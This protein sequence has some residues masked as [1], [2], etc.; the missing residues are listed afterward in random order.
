M[1]FH[2]SGSFTSDIVEKLK[3]NSN[4]KKVKNDQ[5]G[6]L[7]PTILEAINDDSKNSS[8]VIIGEHLLHPLL[9]FSHGTGVIGNQYSIKDIKNNFWVRDNVVAPINAKIMPGIIK[10]MIEKPWMKVV[11]LG[12]AYTI[13]FPMWDNLR[14]HT[15]NKQLFN[16]HYCDQYNDELGKVIEA[17]N[18]KLE[19][20]GINPILWF[21]VV[22]SIGRTPDGIPL[23]VDGVH[24]NWV[25]ADISRGF[26]HWKKQFPGWDGKLNISSVHR[27]IVDVI[28]N[29]GCRGKIQGEINNL[30]CYQ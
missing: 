2:W 14:L 4:H 16:R 27:S 28:F 18:K 24:F 6:K 12:C 25:E 22:K 30:C 3:M 11:F 23:A 19:N 20:N 26:T 5:S 1:K 13:H 29:I 21:P 10:K 7:A 15:E 17:A 8:F 9:H